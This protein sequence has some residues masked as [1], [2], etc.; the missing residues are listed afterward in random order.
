MY[1]LIKNVNIKKNYLQHYCLSLNKLISINIF[2]KTTKINKI[3]NITAFSIKE[4]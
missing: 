4:I 2:L 1:N 3:K